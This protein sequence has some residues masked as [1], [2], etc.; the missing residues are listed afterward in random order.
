MDNATP[1][2]ACRLSVSPDWID[3]NGHMNV[4]Y[5]SVAFDKAS[6]ALLDF[7]ELGEAYRYETGASMF[8]VESHVTYDREV[9]EGDPLKFETRILDADE[10]RLHMFHAMYHEEDGYLAA[11]T[12]LMGLH[13][14][15]TERRAKPFPD[16]VQR[17]IGTLLENHRRLAKP[18]QCGRVIGIRRKLGA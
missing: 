18:E 2:T 14:D 7:L 12:E 16:A 4:G 13:V 9:S 10:K 11:T 6:D 17:Q 5:Y 3:Y 15:L 1:F 8:I